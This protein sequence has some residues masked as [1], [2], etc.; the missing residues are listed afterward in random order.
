MALTQNGR[1]GHLPRLRD[2]NHEPTEP[3]YRRFVLFAGLVLRWLGAYD[4]RGTEKVPARGGVL[5]VANHTSDFDPLAVG[6][7]LIWGAGRWVRYLGK[8]QIFRTP[9]LGWLA[10][11]CGQIPVD[12]H[13]EH[14]KDSLAAAR[15]ALAAG[16]CVGIYPEGT[17]GKDPDLWPMRGKTG[18]ARLALETD[19]PVIPLGQ[20]GSQDFMP[21]DKPGFPFVLRRGQVFRVVAG[22]PIDFDDLRAQPITKDLLEEATD[23]II[24]AITAQVAIAR[25]EP[26]PTRRWDPDLQRHVPVA[27][28]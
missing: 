15:A 25:G 10:R 3:T 14:A 22:D 9:V 26:V 8:I 17:V 23:R 6:M 11:A 27:D 13:S 4:W 28:R 5:V 16:R 12:R 2:V 20:W 21:H 18:A 24:D 1:R 7:F 19:V